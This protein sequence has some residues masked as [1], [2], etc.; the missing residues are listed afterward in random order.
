MVERPL[1]FSNDTLILFFPTSDTLWDLA[2][3][4]A[5]KRESADDDGKRV[6]VSEKSLLF[7]GNKNGVTLNT[8]QFCAFRT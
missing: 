4:E 6:E 1:F 3:A 2:I 5:E 7:M 8:E